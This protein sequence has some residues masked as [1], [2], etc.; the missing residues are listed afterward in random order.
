MRAEANER[1]VQPSLA[2]AHTTAVGTR[3]DVG[4]Y[5]ASLMSALK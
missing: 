4:D 1:I 5:A 2:A 3:Y